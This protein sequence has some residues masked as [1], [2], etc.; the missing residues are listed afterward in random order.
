MK[1]LRYSP[2][3][4]GLRSV[5]QPSMRLR[6]AICDNPARGTATR[7]V[8]K[9]H[10]SRWICYLAIGRPPKQPR[11]GFDLASHSAPNGR[12]RRYSP[13]M[14]TPPLQTTKIIFFCEVLAFAYLVFVHRHAELSPMADQCRQREEKRKYNRQFIIIKQQR[15]LGR[16]AVISQAYG[17]CAH[18]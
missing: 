2:P 6:S 12:L 14:P 3:R 4:L 10:S 13:P 5:M 8:A 18:G 15:K 16:P 17:A 7:Y 11:R 9:R 1:L